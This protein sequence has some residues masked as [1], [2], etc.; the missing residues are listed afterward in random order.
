MIVPMCLVAAITG[1][2]LRGQDN[3]ILTQIGFVVLIGLAAKNAILIVEFAKQAEEAGA[4]RWDAAVQAAR[5][6]LRPIL[7]TSLAFILGVVPLVIATGAGAELRQAHAE[8]LRLAP[9]RQH[10]PVIRLPLNWALSAEKEGS[11]NYVNL[12][13]TGLKV[14]RICL[15]CMTYGSSKW[16]DWVLDYDQAKPFI[17]KAFDF[18]IN[19]YDTADV[20]SLGESEVVLGKA[21]K[22]FGVE[23]DKVVIA[24]K[25]CSPMGDDPNLRGLSRKHITHA[26]DDSLRRLQ[27][28]YVDLYLIHWPIPGRSGPGGG[29][30]GSQR[31]DHCQL[32]T[33]TIRRVFYQ[34]SSIE[35]K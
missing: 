24:T 26:I 13:S 31:S 5:T 23:R 27:L 28:D 12:G 30:T 25:V 4:N 11:M 15:G 10:G 33:A 8:R 22:E 18:G 20:Y 6:R 2:I 14:S 29:R 1:V 7:M 17:R 19:F 16:R 35:S 21:L 9:R 32:H 3:N 34:E